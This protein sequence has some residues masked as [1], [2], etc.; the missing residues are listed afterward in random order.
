ML[1]FCLDGFI[2]CWRGE[3]SCPSLCCHGL[4]IWG[5]FWYLYLPIKPIKQILRKKHPLIQK[6][7][8]YKIESV[9]IIS[10]FQTEMKESWK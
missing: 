2:A 9:Q 7:L 8:Y 1:P 10:I 4:F 3:V 6:I 5:D